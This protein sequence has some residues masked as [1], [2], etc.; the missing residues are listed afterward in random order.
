MV[1]R[2]NPPSRSTKN[3]D[4]EDC[5]VLP[6]VVLKCFIIVN[7]S[8][9]HNNYTYK[10]GTIITPFFTGELT[11]L[12]QLGKPRVTVGAD[13]DSSTGESSCRACSNQN[14][15]LIRSPQVLGSPF[16]SAISSTQLEC[17]C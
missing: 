12:E 13:Q 11:G 16:H 8:D 2:E 9:A 10:I 4:H 7:F 5:Y 17:D 14:I 3:G 1:F 15:P 6:G